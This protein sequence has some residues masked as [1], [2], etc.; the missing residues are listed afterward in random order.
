MEKI[1][2]DQP[3]YFIRLEDPDRVVTKTDE[4]WL[5]NAY[6]GQTRAKVHVRLPKGKF[7]FKYTVWAGLMGWNM[8]ELRRTR[9]N[10]V[11]WRRPSPWSSGTRTYEV[12]VEIPE[13]GEYYFLLN[14]GNL[15]FEQIALHC[16]AWVE[17]PLPSIPP[18]VA[19]G[20]IALG[21]MALSAIAA[22]THEKGLWKLPWE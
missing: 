12:E 21:T 3:P 19:V 16:E 22:Y 7:R 4:W 11:I 20:S 9:D 14:D 18:H 17:H 1:R 2:L 6:T 13:D 8:I 15:G 10:R 5:S